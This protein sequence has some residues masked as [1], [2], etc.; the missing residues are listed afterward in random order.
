MFCFEIGEDD[1]L[2]TLNAIYE[3]KLLKTNK[4]TKSKD[5]ANLDKI[6]DLKM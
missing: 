2:P 3:K 4:K 5:Y 1:S 6:K